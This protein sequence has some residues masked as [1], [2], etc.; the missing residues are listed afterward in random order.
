[1]KSPK[2]GIVFVNPY[3]PD[4]PP[5]YFGP[6]YGISLIAASMISA[7][8]KIPITAYDFDLQERDFMLHSV[9]KILRKEEPA[10]LAIATQSCTRGGVYELIDLARRINPGINIIL[11]GPFALVNTIFCLRTSMLIM[12]WLVMARKRWLS[13]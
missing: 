2:N 5:N 9:E 13:L 6:P 4:P 8:I 11:G 10:Y 3:N 7:G 12:S 1:M